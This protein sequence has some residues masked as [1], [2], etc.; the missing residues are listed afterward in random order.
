MKIKVKKEG[1]AVPEDIEVERRITKRKFECDSTDT[2]VEKFLEQYDTGGSKG[3]PAGK[4]LNCGGLSSKFLLRYIIT[5]C[6]IHFITLI[7]IR[8]AKLLCAI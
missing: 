1:K 5:S 8:P 3:R 6:H 7:P 2:D 4:D